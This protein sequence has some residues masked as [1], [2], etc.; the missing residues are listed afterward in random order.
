M[1][2]SLLVAAVAVFGLSNVNAQTDMGSWMFGGGSSFS[3]S[4]SKSTPEFD[5]EELDEESKVSSINF[6]ADANYFIVENLAVGVELLVNTTKNEIDSPFGEGEYKTNS[7]GVLPGAT[8]YF[9]NDNIA[10]FVGAKIGY[11]SA[12]GEED[13]SKF[14]G[15]AY[16]GEAGVAFFI[17]SNV[18]VDLSVGYLSSKLSNKEEEDYKQKNNTLAAGFG[19]SVYF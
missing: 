11:M 13:D 18:S 1:K 8:Y 6:T 7:F 4:S 3:F 15:L 12:G 16:G 17:N 19:F 2:K 14:S 5:G 10:P 9:K